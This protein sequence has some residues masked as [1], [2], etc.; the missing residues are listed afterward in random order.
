MTQTLNILLV[1]DDPMDAESFR[2]ALR[3]AGL[4]HRVDVARNGEEA[5]AYLE[6]AEARAD[7]IVADLKMPRMGGLEL[8]DALKASQRWAAT[9]VVVLSTSR[10]SSDRLAAYRRGAAGFLVKPIDFESYV[11]VVQALDRYWTINE[12]P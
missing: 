6:P 11:E 10:E 2:R 8:L 12:L 5:L 1:E 4:A 3:D 9:P 7:L